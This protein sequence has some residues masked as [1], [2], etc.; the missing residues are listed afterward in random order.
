MKQLDKMI[1]SKHFDISYYNKDTNQLSKE[2]P[3]KLFSNLPNPYRVLIVTGM[4][5]NS[6]QL[7]GHGYRILSENW[8]YRDS[9]DWQ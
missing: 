1:D 9:L 3:E 7:F 8:Y 4:Y 5:G 2:K 6:N